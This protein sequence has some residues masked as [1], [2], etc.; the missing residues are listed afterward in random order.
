MILIK[1]GKNKLRY[2]TK[3]LQFLRKKYSM[4]SQRDLTAAFNAEF[5]T[6]KNVAQ[7]KS[8]LRNHHIRSG[9]TGRFE[10]GHKTWNKETKG[11]TGANSTSF[12][13]GNKPANRKPLGAERIDS[14]DGYIL[15]KIK[16]RDPYF[17]FP[18]RYKHKHVHVW[19]KKHGPVSAGHIIAFK[20]SNRMNCRLKNLM[21]LSRAELLVLNQHKYREMPDELKPSV[22][23]LA[24]LE[25]KAG[26]RTCPSRGLARLIAE[27]DRINAAIEAIQKYA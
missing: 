14:K 17:G 8:V 21:L 27:R 25:A 7:I 9:R 5:G 11:L 15:M 4:I 26:I 12:K 22:L 13:K 1:K 10:K 18:T 6:A 20:D 16:E 24:K 2:T 3:Q 19:E 23:A